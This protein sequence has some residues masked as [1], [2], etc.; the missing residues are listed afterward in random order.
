MWSSRLIATAMPPFAEPVELGENHA[1]Q[2]HRLPEQA[3]LAE[4]VLAGRRIEHQQG[5]VRGIRVR[6]PDDRVDLAQLFHE[7]V[8]GL[9]AA[10]RVDQ[11]HI[12]PARGTRGHRIERDR[13]RV[14]AGTLTHQLRAGTVCPDRKLIDRRRPEGIGRADHD[15]LTE[16]TEPVCQLAD[17]GG[18]AA[19]VDA[20]HKDHRG[21]RADRDPRRL[22][23]HLPGH[24][25]R[26]P[27]RDLRAVD[28]PALL[29]LHRA[30]RRP[31]PATRPCRNRRR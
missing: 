31:A 9:Q 17:S 8:L 13:A 1:G 25:S 21:P 10:R 18:L 29:G 6:L 27:R 15:L 7:I 19:A 28:D 24:G 2:R 12:R 16:L 14:G 22:R 3:R 20:N 11:H 30:V 5:L 4:P 26:K 23:G